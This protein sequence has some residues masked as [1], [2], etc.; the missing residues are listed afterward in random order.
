[1]AEDRTKKG[2]IPGCLVVLADY[3][4]AFVPADD[5]NEPGG[6]VEVRTSMDIVLDLADMASI[7]IN[8]VSTAMA[9]A[10]FR[11]TVHADRGIGWLMKRK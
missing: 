3:I 9:A 10:G 7:E 5:P 6:G 11:M 4:G 2:E 1:M 8:D